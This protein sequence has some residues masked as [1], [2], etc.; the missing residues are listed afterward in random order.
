MGGRDKVV[1]FDLENNKIVIPIT[2]PSS[3]QQTNGINQEKDLQ[4]TNIILG[5]R[6]IPQNTTQR[7]IIS[8]SSLGYSDYDDTDLN[9]NIFIKYLNRKIQ[10]NN[11]SLF[12]ETYKKGDL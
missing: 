11:S 3:D 5:L 10:N 8:D 9:P 1:G 2:P 7:T 4:K 12:S 6:R